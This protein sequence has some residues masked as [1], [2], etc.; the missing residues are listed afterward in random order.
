MNTKL[1]AIASGALLAAAALA[2]C[3]AGSSGN[4]SGMGKMP[5]MDHGDSSTDTATSDHNQADVTF[6]EGMVPH[7]GQAIEMS[8]TLLAKQGVD[9]RVTDLAQKIKAAQQPEID[10]LRGWLGTWG[11]KTDRGGMDM[12]GDGMMSQQDMDALKNASGTDASKL[13]L[14]QMIQHHQGAITMATTEIEKGKA[15]DAVALA[16]K[17][18]A[19]QTAEITTM[20]E[21][22]A[23]L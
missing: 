2:G 6:A 19:A 10:T 7:H 21:L 8:D 14:A 5:G 16:T 1:I 9:P 15:T 4:D 23:S 11:Q 18:A 20:K 3:T 17:I 22:L 13:F 12:G